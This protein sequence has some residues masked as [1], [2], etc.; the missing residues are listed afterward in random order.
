ML[1]KGEFAK[2]R[3]KNLKRQAR[4]DLIKKLRAAPEGG[5]YFNALWATNG[6]IKRWKTY[7][8]D[9][10]RFVAVKVRDQILVVDNYSDKDGKWNGTV[11]VYP[12]QAEH[13]CYVIPAGDHSK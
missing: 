9:S 11:V 7:N 1:A 2:K 13:L 12:S 4:F 5:I 8:G 3:A 6:V 10:S